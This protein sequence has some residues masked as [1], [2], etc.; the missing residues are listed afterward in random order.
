MGLF[1]FSVYRAHVNESFSKVCCIA[2]MKP[3]KCL[4]HFSLSDDIWRKKQVARKQRWTWFGWLPFY[5]GA[6]CTEKP[7]KNQITFLPIPSMHHWERVLS[8]WVFF[9]FLGRGWV[10]SPWALN[11][12]DGGNF[13]SCWSQL[14]KSNESIIDIKRPLYDKSKTRQPEHNIYQTN[15]NT[16]TTR[17]PK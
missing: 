11:S 8:C 4:L 15:E 2:C 5:C 6:W 13:L 3:K 14:T 1:L 7:Y 12:W 16:N 9:E 10:S 17:N